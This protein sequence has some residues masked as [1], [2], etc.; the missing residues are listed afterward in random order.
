[1][2]FRSHRKIKKFSRKCLR[3]ENKN[4]RDVSNERFRHFCERGET[5]GGNDEKSEYSL[6]SAEKG[7]KKSKIF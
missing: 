5:V 7:Q 2:L 6:K 3:G 1:M 4:I